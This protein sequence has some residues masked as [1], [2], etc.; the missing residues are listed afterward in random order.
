LTKRPVS[1]TIQDSQSIIAMK[2]QARGPVIGLG[3]A[4]EVF[5][6]GSIRAAGIAETT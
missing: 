1:S 6:V 2:T 4:V 3:I 5:E